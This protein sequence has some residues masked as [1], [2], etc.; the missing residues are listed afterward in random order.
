VAG[1]GS[2]SV[3]L[4]REEGSVA[5]ACEGIEAPNSWSDMAVATVAR[6]YLGRAPDGAPE[7]SVRVAVERVVQTIGSWAL[8]FRAMSEWLQRTSRW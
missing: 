1:W 5:F 7:R 3:Q 6:R 4:L 2:R 8:G